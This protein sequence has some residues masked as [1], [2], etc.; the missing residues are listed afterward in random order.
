MT[1]KN[2]TIN[3]LLTYEGE[4][5][6]AFEILREKRGLK[7]NVELLRQLVREAEDAAGIILKEV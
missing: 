3:M 7:N 1:K 5:A 6:R 2:E 4:E